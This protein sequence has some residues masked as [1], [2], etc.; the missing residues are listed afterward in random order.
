MTN[1][2][3]FESPKELVGHASEHIDRLEAE[4]KSFF[5]RKP[6]A[7]VVDFDRETREYVFKFRLTAKLP[8]KIRLVFKDATSNLRD[9]L[10]HA[11]YAAAISLGNATV[12]KTGFP[13]ANDAA[14]LEGEFKTWKF[15]DVPKEI[16]PVLISFRPYP[17]GNDLLIGLNRMRN[18][19]THRVIVPVGFASSGNEITNF[20]GTISGSGKLGYSLWDAAKNEVEYM[21]LGEGSKAKCDVSIAFD[22][23]FGEVEVFAGKPVVLSLREIM[24]EVDRVVH[25][26]EV[27]TAR[28]LH[29]RNP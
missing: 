7:R 27:E 23:T 13:F 26:L 2:P 15:S 6:C 21:R 14:H 29:E 4:I 17:T 22:V 16:H 11:V 8:S 25:G 3:A 24:T 1:L 12:E 28:I 10:D 5:D 20:T 19:N 18:P 9:A